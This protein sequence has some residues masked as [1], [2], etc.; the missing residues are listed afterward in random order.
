[1]VNYANAKILA[2]V[3]GSVVVSGYP[4]TGTT[5]LSLALDA[6][7]GCRY[8]EGSMSFA[9]TKSVIHCHFRHLPMSALFS[10]RR[11]ENVIPSYTTHI[12]A[13]TQRELVDRLRSGQERRSDVT[14]IQD[15]A[16]KIL[17]GWKRYPSPAEYYEDL[18]RRSCR[19]VSLPALMASD[20]AEIRALAH[21][22]G[23]TP[24]DVES[25]LRE[26]SD[27]YRERSMSGDEFYNRPSVRVKELILS[28]PSLA[29]QIDA[30]DHR[31]EIAIAARVPG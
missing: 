13:D 22:V 18:A 21:W 17:N 7:T 20:P 6:M 16:R 8:I 28:D 29:Q 11:L 30:Q 2:P 12:L 19:V 10:Y 15:S 23:V 14:L 9:W 3:N 27:T 5:Y 26:A 31:G 25:A 4:K 24:A 1:M